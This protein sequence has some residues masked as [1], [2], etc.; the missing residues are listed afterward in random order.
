MGETTL[1]A[2]AYAA[3]YQHRSVREQEGDVFRQANASVL[4]AQDGGKISRA[5]A[6]ADND[7]LW[8]AVIDLVKDQNNRL[9][10]RLKISIVSVGLTVLRDLRSDKPD[11]RFIMSMNESMAA[12]LSTKP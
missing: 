7:R 11:F 2:R 6:L 1:A 8:S 4:L 9:P 5:R 12:A 3:S 10:Q